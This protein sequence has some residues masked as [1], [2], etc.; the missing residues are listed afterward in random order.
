MT[1]SQHYC[2]RYPGFSNCG[3]CVIFSTMD[4]GMMVIVQQ[5]S[6]LVGQPIRQHCSCEVDTSKTYRYPIP[7][8]AALVNK[9]GLLTKSHYGK[10]TMRIMNYIGVCVCSACT[11]FTSVEL[12]TVFAMTMQILWELLNFPII[13]DNKTCIEVTGEHFAQNV[14]SLH[15]QQVAM[16]CIARQ[17]S[18][19][20]CSGQLGRITKS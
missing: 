18:Y 13:I 12:T 9:T 3:Q 10:N 11:L 1:T 4:R 20:T 14:T 2:C 8:V 7:L 17:I 15:C 19:S 5:A 6:I 16:Y